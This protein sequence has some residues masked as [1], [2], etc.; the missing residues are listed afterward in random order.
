MEGISV[1]QR[2]SVGDITAGIS[3]G[4]WTPELG[5]SLMLQ[6]E[7]VYAQTRGRSEA[8]L[9]FV[10]MGR[11]VR[12]DRVAVREFIARNAKSRR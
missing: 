11:Y 5:Q 4:P 7:L 10:K 8:G 9:P 1:V 3:L 6:N 12:F 2:G